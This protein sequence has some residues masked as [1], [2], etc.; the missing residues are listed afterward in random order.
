MHKTILNIFRLL[1][2]IPR[3]WACRICNVLGHVAFLADKRHKEIAL[4][5]LSQAYGREKYPQEMRLLAKKVF[6][7]LT[8]IVFEIGWSLRLKRKDFDVFFSIEGLANLRNAYDK[9]KGVIMLTGHLGNWELFNIIMK[10]IGFPASF[11][12]RP[13][14]SSS[15]NAFFEAYRTRLGGNLIPS[16]WSAASIVRS[17]RRGELVGI[18]LDQNVAWYEGVF[19]NFFG[20]PA[21]TN[22]GMALLALKTGA[23]VVP[24]FL[25]REGLVFKAKIGKEISVVKTGDMTK[26]V[27]TNTQ[28]YNDVIESFVRRHPD[29]WFWVHQRWKTKHCQPWPR[30]S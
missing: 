29:Q 4:N 9:G 28:R 10:M 20:R 30:K 12:Y 7:N 1:G 18:L 15:V 19:V 2:L 17:L 21:C 25:V 8:Q 14:D 27:E 24:M 3:T 16:K 23:P 26:D 22:K 6:K 13:L 5:N 11:V